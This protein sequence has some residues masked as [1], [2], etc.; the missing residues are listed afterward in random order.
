[1]A[2]SSVR[3]GVCPAHFKF[4]D[5][6]CPDENGS[7]PRDSDGTIKTLSKLKQLRDQSSI[8]FS[9]APVIIFTGTQEKDIRET[10]I[11]I[12]DLGLEPEV[13][14]MIAGVDPMNKADEDKFV[15]LAV[16]V[17]NIAKDVGIKSVTS[18]SFEEWMSP[19]PPKTG[20]QYEAAVEQVVK[21]HQRAYEE[22]ELAHSS[23]T[24]WHLEF[25]RPV[26]YDTFTNINTAWDVVRKLNKRIGDNFFRVLVD[27]SHCGDSG[28]PLEENKQTIR[29]IAAAGALGAFHASSKTTRG[30]LTS[31]EGWI[32]ELL[33][34]C[35][36]TGH[37]ETVI[38]EAFNHTDDGLEAL[39]TAV[40]GHGVDTTKGRS[41]NELVID[42]LKIVSARLEELAQRQTLAIS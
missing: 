11:G 3:M 27:A 10:L 17:L 9:V 33:T 36:E 5:V 18:P 31:D 23:I 16:G 12:K 20:S 28:L 14:M 7:L 15:E 22:A 37:L 26:E 8:P 39:R 30:C 38:V 42:G 2:S 1:M 6:L 32:D 19:G 4:A 40:P 13:V 25:L 24:S 29:Q 34:T 41:Y 35:F 21:N